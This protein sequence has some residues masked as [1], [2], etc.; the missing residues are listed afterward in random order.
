MNVVGIP[1]DTRDEIMS[2]IAAVLHLGNIQFSEDGN[3][4]KVHNSD[5][6]YLKTMSEFII[7]TVGVSKL[8]QSS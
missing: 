6:K 1:N 3:Y 4:A 7:V 5:C 2:L 8:C